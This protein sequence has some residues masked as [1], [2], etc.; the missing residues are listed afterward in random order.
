MSK[1]FKDVA[2]NKLKIAGAKK[3][4]SFRREEARRAVICV[5]LYEGEMHVIVWTR[6]TVC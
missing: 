5:Q 1:F 4:G 6:L 2:N 3:K